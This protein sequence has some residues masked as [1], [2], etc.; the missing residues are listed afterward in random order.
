MGKI[1]REEEGELL[2]EPNFTLIFLHHGG[3]ELQGKY[4]MAGRRR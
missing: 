4:R 1:M 2:L 3:L